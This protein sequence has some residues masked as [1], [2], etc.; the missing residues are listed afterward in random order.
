MLNA[1]RLFHFIEQTT[2]K[3]TTQPGSACACFFLSFCHIKFGVI[4]YKRKSKSNESCLRLR[5]LARHT[6]TRF[7]F[8]IEMISSR[9]RKKMFR[10][11]ALFGRK[12][13]FRSKINKKNLRRCYLN[14]RSYDTQQAL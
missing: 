8:D 14:E 11:V 5:C 12:F 13:L 3:P 10:L 7:R 9:I 4:N 1:L 6:S 2:L